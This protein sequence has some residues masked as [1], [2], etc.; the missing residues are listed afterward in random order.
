MPAPPEI[1]FPP[2]SRA[3][4]EAIQRTRK[5]IAFE[6]A[7][8]SAFYRGRLDGVNARKLDDPHE[9]RKIPILTKE[10]LR[11]LDPGQFHDTF[12][13][14]PSEHA[15]EYWRSGGATG[16][17]LFYPRSADDLR[18]A[19]EGF[20]RLWLAAGC[21]P[22]DVAM[23]SFPLGIHPVG[24]LYART[25]E[26]LGIGTIWTGSG[27]NT[28]SEMQVELLRTLKPTIWAGMASY[29]LQLAQIAERKGIDL[30]QSSVRKYLTA[31][32]PV[33]KA[34]REKIERL[35]NAELVDQFGCTEGSAMGSESEKHDGLHMW[36]DMF[37][38][39]VVDETS[40]KPVAEGEPGL[41]VMTPLWNNTMTPFLRWN[42]GDIVSYHERGATDGPLA[43]FPIVRHAAR[44]AG[45]FKLRG[46]NINHADF[47]D[48]MHRLI[49]VSDFKAEALWSGTLDVLRVSV[50][51]RRGADAAAVTGRIGAELRKIFEIGA[52]IV[53]IEPGTVERELM[54][55]VK[56]QRIVD[57]R[58]A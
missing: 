12:C 14:A 24:H 47:E 42:T 11:Q 35:W 48:V 53:V 49:E 22:G 21:K 18:L 30:A 34:K 46:V 26:E 23:I 17:P 20:R 51:L 52:E 25:A 19:M 57:R 50:E 6:R 13:I 36:T 40:G 37:D 2:R 45:F 31:A 7:Q 9:W 8:R 1:P 29:G 55:Q 39:E 3:E 44:T 10:E 58:G 38:I 28:P 4:I 27:N 54:A 33:S 15:V 16:R 43:V 56:P 5:K 32:E 41:M